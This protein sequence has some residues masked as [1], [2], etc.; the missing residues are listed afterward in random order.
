MTG[1]SEPRLWKRGC[2]AKIWGWL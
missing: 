1:A 2:T